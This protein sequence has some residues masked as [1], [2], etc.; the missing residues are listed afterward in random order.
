MVGGDAEAFQTCR[1]IFDIVGK[2]VT[3]LGPA[4]NGQVCKACNQ[5][6][7]ACS[8]VGAAEAIA[9]AGRMGLDPLRMIEVVQAGAGGSWQLSNLGPKMVAGD[10]A[11]GFFVDYLLKDL[12]IVQAAAREA[13]LE[14]PTAS[15]AQ[16]RLD[17][18]ASRGHSR[19]GTQA[20]TATYDD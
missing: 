11:P 17:A 18:A 3:H 19:D 8:L 10:Y 5:V 9:L 16:A 7:V 2:T 6:A 1:P 13:G 12:A 14:L 4:G 15:A 20:V